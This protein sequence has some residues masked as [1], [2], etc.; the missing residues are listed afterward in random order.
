MWG[1]GDKVRSWTMEIMKG[2]A[3]GWIQPFVDRTF[4]FEE[5]ADAHRYMEARKNTGKIVLVP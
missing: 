3:D 1:E 4:R 2:V 5:I